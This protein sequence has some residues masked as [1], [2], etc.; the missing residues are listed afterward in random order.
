MMRRNRTSVHYRP[1]RAARYRGTNMATDA[2]NVLLGRRPILRLAAPIDRAIATST[3]LNVAR[4]YNGDASAGWSA[5]AAALVAAACTVHSRQ[6]RRSR[7]GRGA[8]R[9][10]GPRSRNRCYVSQESS[11]AVRAAALPPR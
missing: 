5:A 1:R 4:L 10:V 6:L 8:Q 11:T 7:R 9:S 2:H 3:A